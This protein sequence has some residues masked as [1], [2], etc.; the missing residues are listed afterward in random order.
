MYVET[1]YTLIPPDGDIKITKMNT[2]D[3]PGNWDERKGK[4]QE[5]LANLTGNDLM[6]EGGKTDEMLGKLELKLGKTKDELRQIITPT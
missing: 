5:K 1:Y 2:T 4:L 6:A 3:Q